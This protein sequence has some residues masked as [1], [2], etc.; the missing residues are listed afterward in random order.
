[1]DPTPYMQGDIFDA[2]M[3]YHLYKPARYFFANTDLKLD[4]AQLKDSLEFLWTK[5]DKPMQ[6]SMMNTAATHDS[7]RLLTSFDNKSL[8]KVWAKP[9]EDSTYNT[10]LPDEET[11]TRVKLY[12]MHQFTIPGAPQIWNGDE[13]GMWGADDPDCRKPLWWNNMDFDD[14]YQNNFQPG[15]KEYTKVTFNEEHFD[16]Y[17][18]IIRIRRDNPVLATGDIKFIVAENNKLMYSRFD[19]NDE[20]I[21]LFNLESEP[22]SFELQKGYSYL[23]LFSNSSFKSSI[24]LEPFSGMILKQLNK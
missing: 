22:E 17:K 21:V 3:F 23:N 14:E 10:G 15:E 1:M 8:Y 7:P 9:H 20:I 16:F 6:Y 2:V 5:L 18:K 12:L 11:Y 24:I 4:A 13:M 19:N